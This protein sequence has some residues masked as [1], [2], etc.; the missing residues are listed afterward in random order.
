LREAYHLTASFVFTSRCNGTQLV[1]I[2]L[3]DPEKREPD[4]LDHSVKEVKTVALRQGNQGR[5]MATRGSHPL[6][7]LRRE[8][9]T[10]FGP[11]WS[12]WEQETGEMRFWDFDVREGEN[13][14]MVRA[15]VPG[16][17]PNELDVEM[18]NDTL[19]IK[20]EKQHTGDR[21]EEYR[22]FYRSISLPGGVDT[23]K[24]QATYRN[25]VLELHI[26]RAAGA[27]PR[28]IQ[29]QA[30]QGGG[31]PQQVSGQVGASAATQ[32][33]QPKTKGG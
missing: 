12:P 3:G 32:Q 13:E 15:E 1:A 30:E 27:S 19:T 17:E 14:I 22:S 24:A 26:P 29:V 21:G 6:E 8:F 20:A 2:Y 25:G 31:Q 28:R 9:E 18:H 11:M 4:H 7:R 10:L 16:F 33:S 23:E 5:Q